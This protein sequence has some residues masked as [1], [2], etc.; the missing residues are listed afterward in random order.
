MQ[1]TVAYTRRMKTLVDTIVQPAGTA[2]P[3]IESM[4][5]EILAAVDPPGVTSDADLDYAR[6]GSWGNNNDLVASGEDAQAIVFDGDE[7]SLKSRCPIR[8]VSRVLSGN[9]NVLQALDEYAQT[10]ISI[11]MCSWRL[12]FLPGPL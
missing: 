4:V 10:Y 12:T 7:N 3:I 2:D 5:D 11:R 8:C 6:W 9:G 1:R